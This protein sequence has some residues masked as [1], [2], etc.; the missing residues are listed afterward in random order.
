MK[1]R[2][3]RETTPY[4]F[5]TGRTST[6]RRISKYQRRDGDLDDQSEEKLNGA[7]ESTEDFRS[8]PGAE[9]LC[10]EELEFIST[11]KIPP[12]RYAIFK[13]VILR[14]ALNKG[15]IQNGKVIRELQIDAATSDKVYDFFVKETGLFV[16]TAVASGNIPLV[17]GSNGHDGPIQRSTSSSSS[18]SNDASSISTKR[19]VEEQGDDDDNSSSEHPDKRSR[20]RRD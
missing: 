8:M 9:L 7:Q 3:Q 12:R 11:H 15:V 18:E 14:E 20:Q 19:K 2:K 6:G 17:D 13:D 16:G 4:L 10:E 1:T 5:E